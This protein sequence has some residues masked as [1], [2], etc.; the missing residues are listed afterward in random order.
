MGKNFGKQEDKYNAS[1][2][3]TTHIE[4]DKYKSIN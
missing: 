1:V 3:D 4:A 2:Y